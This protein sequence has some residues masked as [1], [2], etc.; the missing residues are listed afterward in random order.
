MSSIFSNHKRLANRFNRDSSR[1]FRQLR[2]KYDK[3]MRSRPVLIW[4]R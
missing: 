3:L 2:A 4:A 1:D